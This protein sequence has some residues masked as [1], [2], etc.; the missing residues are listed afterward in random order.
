MRASEL[1]AVTPER[2][3]KVD[4]AREIWIK[5]LI[6]LSR[7]N[8]L[9]FYRGLQAGTLDL[10]EAPSEAIHSLLQ[11]G[12]E[13]A[14]GVTLN[15]CVPAAQ[16]QAAAAARLKETASR[17]QLSLE[18]RGLDTLF[19]GLGMATWPQ[20]D[21]GRPTD[22][23]VVLMPLTATSAGRESRV[24]TLKRN[25]DV[26][27]NDVLLHALEIQH[28][29]TISADTLLPDIL[30]DDEGE[31]FDLAGCGIFTGLDTQQNRFVPRYG[32]GSTGMAS[33]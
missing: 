3:E 21:E 28:G 22:A 5:K 17:A 1:P 31:A 20:D 8:N 18:E 29:V 16:Q 19:L 12:R 27:V 13:G 32:Q 30:G 14:G 11:S 7:R 2:R 10:S 6:D 26:R 23:P 4:K 24:W 33:V 25:G 15:K 9:L